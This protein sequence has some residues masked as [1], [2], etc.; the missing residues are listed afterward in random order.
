MAIIRMRQHLIDAAVNLSN[1][2]EPPGLDPEFPWNEIRSTER[3]LSNA[4]QWWALATPDD[5]AYVASLR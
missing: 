3:I 1:G 5:P 4:E 2:I